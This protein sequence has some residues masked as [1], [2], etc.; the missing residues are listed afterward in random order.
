MKEIYRYR[1]LLHLGTLLL[2]DQDS[3]K[4]QKTLFDYLP[5]V[6][7]IDAAALFLRKERD[8]W[9]LAAASA[10]GALFKPLRSRLK[11]FAKKVDE[12]LK[13]SQ[14]MTGPLIVDI[15]MK[16]KTKG[17]SMIVAFPLTVMNRVE[18]F[19]VAARKSPKAFSTDDINRLDNVAAILSTSMENQ[20]VVQKIKHHA[21]SLE[22]ER[23]YLK[24]TV[25]E[26]TRELT[27]ER[28]FA[29]FLSE[30]APYLVFILNNKG[31]VLFANLFCGQVVGYPPGELRGKKF[32]DLLHPAE[33]PEK[34]DWYCRLFKTLESQNFQTTLITREGDHRVIT[35]SAVKRSDKKGSPEEVICIGED[36]TQRAHLEAQNRILFETLPDGLIRVNDCF[37]VMEINQGLADLMGIEPHALV[38]KKCYETLCS[39]SRET[40]PLFSQGLET[41]TGEMTLARQGDK[42]CQVLKSARRYRLGSHEYTLETFRDITHLKRMEKKVRDYAENLEKK[43]QQRS[44][45]LKEA[46]LHLIRSEKLAATGRLAASIAHEINSPIYGIKGCLQSILEEVE[47]GKEMRTFVKLAVKET[48]RISDLVRRMQNFHKDSKG[49]RKLENVNLVLRD[50]VLLCNKFLQDRNIILRECFA[51]HLPKVKMCADQIKQVFLNLINNAVEAMPDGGMLT[52]VTSDRG[53]AVEIRFIDT[54]CGMSQNVQERIFDAFFTTKT[55]VKGVGLG[56]PVCWGIIRNHGGRITTESEQGKGTTFVMTLPASKNARKK[57]SQGAMSK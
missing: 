14:S 15:P 9:T 6:I 26:R 33:E 53:A 48:D 34:Q 56:L 51:K 39:E 5:E 49:E 8:H 38:G 52:V 20:F 25:D 54:G 4:I 2:R 35:W 10:E 43:V 44:A 29:S 36:V 50:V 31:A 23:E 47:L 57:K 19:I 11:R 13:D 46:Q 12:G 17:F 45:E 27:K 1:K 18:A 7:D 3:S 24:T 55:A 16:R 42:D 22:E 21:L 30:G 41:F 40:C 32:L 37:E 28:E